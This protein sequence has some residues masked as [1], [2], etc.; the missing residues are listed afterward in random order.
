MENLDSNGAGDGA[1][2]NRAL[3]RRK[4]AC[5]SISRSTSYLLSLAIFIPVSGWIADRFGAR[6]VFWHAIVVFT[7]GSISCGFAESF[8]N[9]VLSRVVQGLGGAMM[10]PVARLVLLRSV[11]K[12]ELV[13]ALALVTIPR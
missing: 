8:W 2:R 11:A 10:V 6:R 7:L 1:A 3:A 5:I 13:S 4:P 9:L 12:A